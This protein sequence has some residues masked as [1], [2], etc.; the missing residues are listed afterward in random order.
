MHATL[1][2]SASSLELRVN[3]THTAWP[4]LYRFAAVAAI[5]IVASIPIALYVFIVWPPPVSIT[6]WYAF[7][8]ANKVAGVIDLDLVL[9]IDQILAVPV[10][11]AL[12][13]TLRDKNEALVLL[14]TVG[15]LMGAVLLVVS[16]EATFTLPMLSD[17]FAAATS[18]LQRTTLLA[19]GQTLL[20]TFN[21][22]AFGV[23]YALVGVSG[24]L[25]TVV[26]LRHPAFSSAVAWTGIATYALAIVPPTIGGIGVA[27]SLLSLAPLVP[28]ELLLARRFLQ[29][30]SDIDAG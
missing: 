18:D 11:L 28:F 6:D 20:A 10:V 24:L 5:T 8:Q 16:R 14:G 7:L 17:Q 3:R 1:S 25:I 15:A 22:T 4:T 23:G 26:M 2:A 19:A 12:Y 9:L 29:L 21:G 30:A 13:V 27:L